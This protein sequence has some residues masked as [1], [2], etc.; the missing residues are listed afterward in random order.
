MKTLSVALLATFY[1]FSLSAQDFR[2]TFSGL[3]ADPTG[4]PL[5]GSKVTVTETRTGVKNETVADSA[6][7]YTAPFL[8]PG[9][10]NIAAESPNFKQYVRQNIHLGAGDHI[11]IDIRLEVGDATQSVS[12]TADAPLLTS[13]NAS[14]GQAITT[15]EVEE[16]PLNGRTPMVLASLSIGVIGYGTAGLDSSL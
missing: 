13:E 14:V 5:P 15:K 11:V 9:D 2:G 1:I 6:G 4:A 3:I 16:L 8:L 10:Y 7:E 12:I